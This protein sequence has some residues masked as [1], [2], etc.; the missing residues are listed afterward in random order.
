MY[1]LKTCP[2]CNGDMAEDRLPDGVDMFCLNC[3]HREHFDSPGV[4]HIPEER[5]MGPT[6]QR[7]SH[8]DRRSKR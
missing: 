6:G 3:G 2:K 8:G 5:G 1:W 4:H 7:L